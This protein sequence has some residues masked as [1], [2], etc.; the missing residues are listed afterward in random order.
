[1]TQYERDQIVLDLIEARR[2]EDWQLI[3]H[4]AWDLINQDKR[5]DQP[6]GN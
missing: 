1:M 3:L 6:E 4:L 5:F 2:T